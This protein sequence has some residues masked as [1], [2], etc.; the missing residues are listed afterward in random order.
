M[1]AL[2]YDSEIEKEAIEIVKKR[3]GRPKNEQ[4]AIIEPAKIEQPVIEQSVIEPIIEKPPEPVIKPKRERSAKQ[5]EITEK[6]RQK[7][8]EA[9]EARK[10]LSEER[11]I[12]ED[13][14][15]KRIK[16]RATKKP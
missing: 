9:T 3:R 2:E 10:K 13:I 16:E 6:M 4:P 1:S 5:K 12:E 14:L 15:L 7:L 11:N 8:K